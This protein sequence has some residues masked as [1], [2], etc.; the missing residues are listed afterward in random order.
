M[1]KEIMSMAVSWLCFL[2][3]TKMMAGLEGEWPITAL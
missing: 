1:T 3:G 2:D